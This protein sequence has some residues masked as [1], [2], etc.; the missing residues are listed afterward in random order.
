[1]KLLYK[2]PSKETIEAMAEVAGHPINTERENSYLRETESKIIAKTKHLHGKIVNSGNAAILIA[3]NAIDGPILI[4]DQGGWHGFKQIAKF[5]NKEIVM[6]ETDYGLITKEYL[7]KI[8]LQK[9]AKNTNENNKEN[10][11][12]SKPAIFLTSFAG[13]TAEQP[14]EEISNW[15][16]KNNVLLV[17]DASGSITDPEKKLANGIYSDIIVGSTS[18]PKVINVGDGGFITTSNNKIFERSK[19]LLKVCRSNDITNKG[20]STEVDFAEDNL[21]KTI[22]ATTYIKNN[23]DNVFHPDKRGTNVIIANRDPHTMIR[24]LKIKFNVKGKSIITNCPNYN[25]IKQR[26]IAIE[27]KNLNTKCLTKENLDE[28][29]ETIKRFQ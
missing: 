23:L 14:I 5:L 28:I 24:N 6:V 19:L 18:S 12:Y 11:E 21:K 2:Q 13:Y 29:I 8:D 9:V 15:C 26:G 16:R 4:P 25:R 27:I 17:E 7:D 10:I 20:I 1:M 22:E 3:M